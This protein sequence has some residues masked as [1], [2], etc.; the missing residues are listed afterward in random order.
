MRLTC[1]VAFTRL[2]WTIALNM[3]LY[4]A[5][6]QHNKQSMRYRLCKRTLQLR[7]ESSTYIQILADDLALNSHLLLR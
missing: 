6:M 1:G 7:W 3:R 2:C 5:G 4:D